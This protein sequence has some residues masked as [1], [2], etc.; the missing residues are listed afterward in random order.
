M[1]SFLYTSRSTDVDLLPRTY[2]RFYAGSFTEDR[3]VVAKYATEQ[4]DPRRPQGELPQ[5]TAAL[6][7]AEL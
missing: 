2:D 5:L 3:I 4:Y 1:G 6:L 7:S